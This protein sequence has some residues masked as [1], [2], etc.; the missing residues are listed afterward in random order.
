MFIE[1][2]ISAGEVAIS[3]LRATEP[4][5]RELARL[6]SDAYAGGLLGGKGMLAAGA[7]ADVLVLRG[8]SLEIKEVIAGGRR[9]MR[10]GK[11][12]KAE[13]FLENSNREVFLSG[14][15]GD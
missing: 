1:E 7:D 4:D 5:T 15:K 9:L 3:D 10:D 2:V 6:V 11:I 8:G 14:K 12:C 13:A